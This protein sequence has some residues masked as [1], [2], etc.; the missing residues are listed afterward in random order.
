MKG[1]ILPLERRL[2]V[3][4]FPFLTAFYHAKRTLGVDSDLNCT[5]K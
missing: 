2:L 5:K 3:V 1:Y 4:V